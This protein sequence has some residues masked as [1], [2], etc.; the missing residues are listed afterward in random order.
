MNDSHLFKLAREHSFSA[1]YTGCNKVKIGCIAVYKGTVLAF[2]ANTDKTHP[3]QKK[4][5]RWRFNEDSATK[6]LPDKCHSEIRVLNQIRYLDIDFS[7]VHLY[8]YRELKNG[9]PALARPCPSCIAAIRN[10]GIKHI[11]YTT[12]DGFAHE[13]LEY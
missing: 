4:Y 1:D 6:Y 7:K 10:F 9:H 2:G 12:Y 13:K 5:N 8:I 3:Q 11:K